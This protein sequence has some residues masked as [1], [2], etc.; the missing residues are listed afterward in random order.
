MTEAVIK[1]PAEE[2]PRPS[3]T[4]TPK[5]GSI[6][7]EPTKIWRDD[8]FRF[9]LDLRD[10]SQS[11]ET[12]KAK[13]DEANRAYREALRSQSFYMN[14]VLSLCVDIVLDRL[15]LAE[16]R[17]LI[18]TISGLARFYTGKGDIVIT[19]EALMKFVENLILY[20]L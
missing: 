13:L 16:R 12:A 2:T 17:Y 6:D 1:N 3:R 7:I 18:R 14:E 11:L 5:P 15:P 19:R 4:K 9:E 8:M 20:S 10:S